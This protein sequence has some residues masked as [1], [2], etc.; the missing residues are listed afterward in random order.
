MVSGSMLA[1]AKYINAMSDLRRAILNLSPNNTLDIPS[2][3][4][5][6]LLGKG[7]SDEQASYG[8]DVIA[9]QI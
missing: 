7:L 3:A 8:S 2:F 4:Y 5:G 6:F 1:A 9:E